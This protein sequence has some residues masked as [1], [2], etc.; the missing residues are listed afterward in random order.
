M[1]VVAY[2][3]F[4]FITNE[5][6]FVILIKLFKKKIM[7]VFPNVWQVFRNIGPGKGREGAE[8]GKGEGAVGVILLSPQVPLINSFSLNSF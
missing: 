1:L 2:C 3:F 5:P 4:A 7:Y 6:F 8:G